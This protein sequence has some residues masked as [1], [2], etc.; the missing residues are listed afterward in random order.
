LLKKDQKIIGLSIARP[1][2]LKGVES[3]AILDFMVLK[4]H[5]H[6]SGVLH[7][8]LWKL[9]RD[10]EKD[11]IVSMTIPRW[12]KT[13]RFFHFLYFK[14]PAVFSLIIKKLSDNIVDEDLFNQNKWHLF[15][16]DSDDA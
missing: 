12:A 11:V 8:G 10:N 15:W 6:A 13:Y 9:A 14:T 16:I 4:E 2:T 3:L 1:T 7:E 5:L